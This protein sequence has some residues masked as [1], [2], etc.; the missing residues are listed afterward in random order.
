MGV[1]PAVKYDECIEEYKRSSQLCW[2]SEKAFWIG[3]LDIHNSRKK[4]YL[5]GK[6]YPKD[7][8]IE[9]YDWSAESRF[10]PMTELYQYKYLIDARGCGWTDRIKMLFLLE[11]PIF[12][13]ERPYIEFWMKC[14]FEN[15]KHYISVKEDFSDLIR[16]KRELDQSPEKYKKIVKEMHEYASKYLTKDY[17]LK[18]LKDVVLKYGIQEKES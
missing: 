9:S 18:Y 3:N 15:G 10:I 2:K 17:A 11:R 7:L 16:K 1:G 4:L 6:K 14:G 12:I 8:E 5:L 13:N